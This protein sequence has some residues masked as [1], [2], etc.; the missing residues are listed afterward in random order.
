MPRFGKGKGM[1]LMRHECKKQLKSKELLVRIIH[2]LNCIQC[3]MQ[4]HQ[5]VKWNML[6]MLKCVCSNN[7]SN[8]NDDDY[9][10]NYLL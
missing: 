2:F 7:G 8:T 3:I 9:D 6:F 1:I 4:Q 5:G 10:D